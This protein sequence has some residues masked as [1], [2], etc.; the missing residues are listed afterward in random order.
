MWNQE[1]MK[2]DMKVA[3]RVLEKREEMGEYKSGEWGVDM[4]KV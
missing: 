1:T 4:I 3:G 2:K